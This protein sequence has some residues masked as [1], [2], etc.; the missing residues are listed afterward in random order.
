MALMRELQMCLHTTKPHHIGALILETA[1]RANELNDLIV[2]DRWLSSLDMFRCKTHADVVKVFEGNGRVL[3][4][5][6]EVEKKNLEEKEE[7]EKKKNV[8]FKTMSLRVR[9]QPEKN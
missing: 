2:H 8:L 3:E 6:E 4:G 7:E 9:S 1:N 5:R